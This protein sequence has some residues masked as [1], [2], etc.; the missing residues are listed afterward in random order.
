MEHGNY[1]NCIRQAPCCILLLERFHW[2]KATGLHDF[3][4]GGGGVV[5]FGVIFLSPCGFFL[6][7]HPS[8]ALPPPPPA[9]SPPLQSMMLICRWGR[10]LLPPQFREGASP[11]RSELSFCPCIKQLPLSLSS[12]GSRRSVLLLLHQLQLFKSV[13]AHSLCRCSPS[14]CLSVCLCVAPLAALCVRVCV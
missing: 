3:N 4:S 2:N 5:C 13:P 6:T 9:S 10:W 11:S 7:V 8:P 14:A 1:G 12:H